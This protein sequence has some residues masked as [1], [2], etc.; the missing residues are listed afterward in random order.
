MGTLGGRPMSLELYL[1][2]GT[3]VAEMPELSRGPITPEVNKWLG[4]AC[5]LLEE[6]GDLAATTQ[7][8]V[9]CQFLT[10]PTREL[11]ARQISTLVHTALAKAELNC[12]PRAY[13]GNSSRPVTS[14]GDTG[15]LPRRP[16]PER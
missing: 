6:I 9:A 13:R 1:Q 14:A 5:A 4:R 12:P 2:L 3:L 7:L 8:Q 15:E 10:G 11:N 16:G